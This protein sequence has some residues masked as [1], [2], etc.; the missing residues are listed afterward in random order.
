MKLQKIY[1]MSVAV[2]IFLILVMTLV[3]KGSQEQ[4]M[5][6]VQ[7]EN[8]KWIERE[9]NKEK[10][11]VD[12]TTEDKEKVIHEDINIR[13]LLKTDGFYQMVHER[14]Q[15]SAIDGLKISYGED[16]QEIEEYASEEVVVVN[17]EEGK[18]VSEK[19]KTEVL[20]AES[21]KI[22]PINPEQK[23]QV[24]SLQRGYGKPTYYGEIEVFATPDGLILVNELPLELYLRGVLPSE[25]PASYELEALKAQAI[26]ARSYGYNHTQYYGY[27]EY[28]AHVDDSTAYQVYNNSK[29]ADSCNQA[30]GETCR[31]K[32][33]LDGNV[34]TT[35]F[36]STS[37]GYTTNVEAWGTQPSDANRYLKGNHIGENEKGEDGKETICFYEEDLPWFRWEISVSESKIEEILKA[38]LEIDFGQ[39]EGLEIVKSGAGEIALQMD[40]VGS[41]QT[42]SVETEYDIRET[43]GSDEYTIYRQDGS[44]VQGNKLLPSAFI[45]IEKTDGTYHIQGGGFGHGIGMSQNGANEMAK[46]GFDYKEIINKFY[47][48]TEIIE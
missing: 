20:I 31:E 29:E 11:V 33:G 47:N 30:I 24:H 21:L 2:L 6:S 42:V 9:Q 7:E 41:E 18:L 12:E 19:L 39:L 40:V 16:F 10:K 44:E 22:T 26:C 34:V 32:L 23:I 27:P 3:K 13:V 46:L 43:L 25:M 1:Y 17:C 8:D 37:S 35:Y 4:V 36:F 14:L 48:E 5:R 15:C 45:T 38:N 28:Y